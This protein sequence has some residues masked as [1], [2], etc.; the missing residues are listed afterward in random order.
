MASNTTYTPWDE[1]AKNMQQ[2]SL[3]TIPTIPI[4]TDNFNRLMQMSRAAR[5]AGNVEAAEKYGEMAKNVLTDNYQKE[6]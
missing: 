3:Q 6:V 5:E 2:T 1:V 4:G